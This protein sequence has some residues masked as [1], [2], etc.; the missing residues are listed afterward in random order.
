MAGESLAGSISVSGQRRLQDRAM[1]FIDVP[2]DPR[3]GQAH[4]AV[5]FGLKE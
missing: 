3:V 5:A 4:V 1:L 2:F